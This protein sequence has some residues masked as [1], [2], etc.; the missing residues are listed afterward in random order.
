MIHW[1]V[2]L[3][4]AMVWREVG[5]VMGFPPATF[6]VM[7]KLLSQSISGIEDIQVQSGNEDIQVQ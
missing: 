6:E 3:G 7:V 5:I 4:I 2:A 1:E